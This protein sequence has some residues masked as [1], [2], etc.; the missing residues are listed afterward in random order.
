[1]CVVYSKHGAYDLYRNRFL[2]RTHR[3]IVYIKHL[4]DT[5]KDFIIEPKSND[6]ISL[7]NII[8]YY[9]SLKRTQRDHLNIFVHGVLIGVRTCTSVHNNNI[10]LYHIL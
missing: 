5:S 3:I 6:G 10:V 8:S 4:A 2:I 7:I 9:N 1:M